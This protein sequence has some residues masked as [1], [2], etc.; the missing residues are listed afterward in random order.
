MSVILDE[1]AVA[2]PERRRQSDAS[3]AEQFGLSA[4]QPRIAVLI[5]C[6]NEETAIGKVVSDFQHAL[7]E[8]VI[9][10]YDNN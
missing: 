7:P 5:P 3:I 1:P 10:V 9:Y 6:R 2:A 4:S 8:A